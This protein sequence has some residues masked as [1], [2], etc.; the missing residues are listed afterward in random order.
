MSYFNNIIYVL[1]SLF[2]KEKQLC[3][4]IKISDFKGTII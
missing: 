3:K 1:L 2:Y 4:T